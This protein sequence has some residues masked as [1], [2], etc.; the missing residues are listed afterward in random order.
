MRWSR[1]GRSWAVV[2]AVN[3]CRGWAL[4]PV[5]DPGGRGSGDL[6]RSTALDRIGEFL[7]DGRV[8]S[9]RFWLSW[10][11]FASMMHY[12]VPVL[13]RP[14]GGKSL[15]DGGRRSWTGGCWVTRTV[16]FRLNVNIGE[17]EKFLYIAWYYTTARRVNGLHAEPWNK[18]ALDL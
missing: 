7:A 18:W 8:Q 16:R 6:G 5:G 2:P 3:R 11:T 1:I 9:T 17:S 15:F 13:L 12:L 4:R 10:G 14:P